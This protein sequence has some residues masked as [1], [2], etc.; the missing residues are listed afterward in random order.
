MIFSTLLPE[1]L[2]GISLAMC[3]LA[4]GMIAISLYHSLSRKLYI[5][6]AAPELRFHTDA[7]LKSLAVLTCIFLIVSVPQVILMS[8]FASQ[9]D[10]L[11]QGLITSLLGMWYSLLVVPNSI[12]RSLIN[13]IVILLLT[14]PFLV[15]IVVEQ[16]S[17]INQVIWLHYALMLLAITGGVI[18]D[19]YKNLYS[20]I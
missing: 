1:I 19:I 2:S 10:I 8:S 11:V 13:T 20:R 3:G 17:L 14:L 5:K 16:N 15:L 7:N 12:A 6:Q 9:R 18:F 4:L